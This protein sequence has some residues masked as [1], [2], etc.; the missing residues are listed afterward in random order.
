MPQ[1][2]A[3]NKGLVYDPAFFSEELATPFGFTFMVSGIKVSLW[4]KAAAKESCDAF[5][6]GGWVQFKGARNLFLG[7]I[8]GRPL[9]VAK[10]EYFFP[11]Q[12]ELPQQLQRLAGEVATALL[13]QKEEGLYPPVWP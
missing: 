1:F 4:L 6:N 2:L 7:V 3:I 5:A 12:I 13:R 10:G 11:P 8:T 9:Q